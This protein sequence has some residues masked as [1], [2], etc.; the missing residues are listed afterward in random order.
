MR[1]FVAVSVA[2][3][4]SGVLAGIVALAAP[5]HPQGASPPGTWVPKTSMPALRGEVAA[6][7]VGDKLYAL[8]GAVNRQAVARNEEYDPRP[9]AGASGRRCRS[10]AITSASRS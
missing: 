1:R 2:C 8:G 10:R 7:V 3:L 4:A 5:A 6:A 9:I